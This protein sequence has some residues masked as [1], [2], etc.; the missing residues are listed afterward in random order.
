MP[1]AD[2]LICVGERDERRADGHVGQR[3]AVIVLGQP[4]LDRPPL[5]DVP[6]PGPHLPRA[7]SA[8]PR[9][10]EVSVAVSDS[11][12][13]AQRSR[14]H[15]PRALSNADTPTGTQ[16]QSHK[17]LTGSRILSKVSMHSPQSLLSALAFRTTPFF[18]SD[19][20]TSLVP[21]ITP[22]LSGENTARSSPPP[23]P[24][25][26]E[27]SASSPLRSAESLRWRACRKTAQSVS[28]DITRTSGHAQHASATG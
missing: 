7:V 12:D 13:L 19:G 28:V 2:A 9:Q 18:N 4:L 17:T 25:L 5:V 11:P 3:R 24:P 6:V 8:L 22:L 10:M 26:G 20:I 23:P 14:C 21:A 1:R 15:I 16:M 27:K